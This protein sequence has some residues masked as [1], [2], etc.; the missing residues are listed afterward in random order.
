MKKKSKKVI[1]YQLFNPE[2]DRGIF[3]SFLILLI[4]GVIFI[5]DAS[6]PIA[7]KQ[8]S[9]KFYFLI[10]HIKSI[11]VGFVFMIA[12]YKCKLETLE[13]YAKIIFYSS[14]ILLVLVLIP[15][16]G[17]KLLGARR[18]IS[19]GFINFQPSEFIKLSIVIYIARLSSSKKKI[20][21]Y[22]FPLFLVSVLIMMQPDFGTLFL[23]AIVIFSQML[24]SDI[25]LLKMIILFIIGMCGS[26]FTIL[27]SDYRRDRLLGYLNFSDN[28]DSSYHLKQILI[29]LGS[30]GISGV[31]M[32][33]SKQK[34]LF[35]P[36][37]LSDSVFAVIAEEVGFIGIFFII[38]LFLYFFIRGIKISMK[39]QNIFSRVLC[40][41]IVVWITMQ[42]F[43]NMAS[44]TVLIP[45]TGIPLP[46]FS[47]GGTSMVSILTAVGIVLNISSKNKL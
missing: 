13:K 38:M 16:F 45:L 35:L 7:E 17:S 32:G 4:L 42:A 6:S 37:S 9:D 39:S 26:L 43:I 8:F 20:Y 44:Q 12:A 33:E 41:G 46:F 40:V 36:E 2:F 30:G 47:Y 10:E 29:S 1:K 19:L 34:F 28:I 14:L 15:S 3:I 27:S 24:I 11:A 23:I 25:S 5:A 31:G 21:S 22:L 18:W